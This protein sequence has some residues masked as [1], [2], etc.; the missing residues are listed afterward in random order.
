MTLTDYRNFDLLI[1]R[2][3][4]K[5][6]AIVVDAPA[7]DA[8]AL[9]DLPFAA[10]EITHLGGLTHRV[11]R[12]IGA[13]EDAGPAAALVDLGQR[14]FDA[15]FR[16]RVGAGL[17]ASLSSA[18]QEGV[19]LRLRLRFEEDAADLAALPW[20]LLYDPAQAH[21]IGLGERSPILRYLALPR[22]RSALLVEPPLRVLAVLASPKDLPDLEVE[23]EW[24]AIQDALAG[25][26]TDGKFVLER[27][28]APTLAGLQERLLGEPVHILHFVGHGIFHA[29]S[30][31]G[32]LA[33]EDARGRSHLVRGEQLAA[34]LRNHDRLRLAY[35]NACEGA[36]ASGQ[37]VFTGLAQTLV[38]E[39]VPA[40]VAMQAE[41]SDPGAI[42][43][44]RA[45]Y[46][47]LAAGRPVDASL[48]QARAALSAADSLEWAIPVLFSRSPDNR[49]FDIRAVLPT[50]DCP[51]P[52]MAP[53]SEAQ[54]E[55]FFGRDHEIEDAVQ[56]LRQHPFLAV[57]GSS[58][59]GKS[60][61][62]YAGVIPALRRSKRFGPAPWEIKTM[63]PSDSR[64]ASGQA[65]P[66]QALAQLLPLPPQSPVPSPQ[67]PLPS[68]QPPTL[69]FVDQ[70]EEVFTLADAD[71]A[72]AFLDALHRLIGQP[73]LF[74]LLTVRAD[75]YS[76]LM[77]SP[78]WPAIRA[79]RLELTPLGDDEL[80]A[81]I[82]EPA[83]RVGV[84]V[85]EALA[86]QLIADAAGQRGVLPLVQEALV[87]LWERVE[88]RALK[89]AAYRAMAEGGRSGLQV[90]IDRRA[91]VV[92]ANLPEG[93]Q[94]LARRTF[95]RLIQ[96]GEGR[97]D[98]RRQQTVDELRAHGDD[99]AL[100]NHTL[101]A[102]VDSRLLTTSGAEGGSRRVDIAHEALIAG[103]PRLH[104][105]LEQR[106]AAEQTRRRLEAEAVEWVQ[107]A[108]RGGLLDEYEL[109][110]AESWLAGEDA[111]ELGYSQ[112]LVELTAASKEALVQAKAKD[113][114][115]ARNR[116]RSRLFA[117]GLVLAM[118]VIA[119][120][121]YFA[122]TARSAQQ[123]AENAKATA[124]T[125]A[126]AEA[127]AR[128]QANA[129]AQRAATSEAEAL[130]AKATAEASQAE[131][132]AAK[133]EVERLSRA[134][135]ADQ[136]TANALKVVDESAPLA[137]LLAVEGL[138]AQDDITATQPY[139]STRIS[140]DF[141][142]A[143]Y[144]TTTTVATGN[145]MAVGSAQS[146]MHELLGKVGGAPLA[147][148]EGAVTALAFS[149]DGRWLATGS[150]DD[151]V[152]LWDMAA[153]D[154]AAAPTV[155]SGHED[156]V[157]AL[158]FSPDG[159]WLAT[160]SSDATVRLWD[161]AAADR[162]AAPTVLSGH[163]EAVSALAF[164]PDGRWLATG[165]NDKTVRLWD[166]AAADPAAAPTVLSGHEGGVWALAFSPD[167][168]WL[169]TGSEDAAARLWDMAAADP[170]AAP[171]VLSGHEGGVWALAFSPDGRWLAT[172][173]EDGAVRL[174]DMAAADP[175]AA[176][177]VLSGHEGAVWALAFSP[178]GRWL[179]TGSS[180]ATVRLWDMAAADRAAAPTVLSGHEDGVWAL[181]F[182]PD[183]RWLATGSRDA[184]VRLWDMA[185]ADPAA[186]PTVLSGHEGGVTDLAFSPDGRWLATGSRDA[187]V[188]L[189]G[190]A[191][192]DPAAAPTVLSG[193]EAEVWDL[194][195][196][197]DGRWLATGSEDGAVRLWDM[198]AADPAAAH[199]VLSGHEYGVAALAF[200]PDGRWLA[201]GSRD[202][203]VR[204]W[205]MAAADPA[206]AP[207]VLS[208]HEGGVT[209]LAFSPDG[210]WL[211]T[212]SRDATVRLWGMAA[213]DPAAAPTVLSGHE[214]EVWDLAFSP[215]GRWLATGSEDGAVRLWDMAAA[216]PAAAHTVLS[217]HEYGVAALAFSPDGRWL[218]TGAGDAY[219]GGAVRL[220]DMAAADPAAAPTVLSG[221]EGWVNAL[222]FS[223][224]GRWLA[225]GSND[226]TVRLWD[227]AAADRAAAPTV[228]SGHEAEVTALAFS[229]D[230]RWLA[231][232]SGEGAVRL[233][234]M[235][236]A[237][238]AAAPTVLS[239]HDRW[240]TA[241]AFSPDG[242]W[243]ATGSYDATVPL[244]TWR[245]EDLIALACRTAGR[246]LTAKEWRVYLQDKPYRQTCALWPAHPSAVSAD[247]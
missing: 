66:L 222:A 176:P 50:P 167:G 91:S 186:A 98:T 165:S 210:R 206:A 7:G 37:S 75:F 32:C 219:G 182:S 76:E 148:H 12:H 168:R 193:H 199:T 6:K 88:R 38:R 103:W 217:G 213:A 239:G 177:T 109:Q 40:A 141:T 131:A 110:G 112:E 175:A 223:P 89:L 97:P 81:A 77:A 144:V 21:F 123:T 240:V 87:L 230:G 56:R 231:T 149:P 201:T 105:W 156:W 127:T 79:N 170:A 125:A 101:Q 51:Y 18:A 58:G 124:E 221:H 238:R 214:A 64:T 85:D 82:V 191:A 67:S 24:Q 232:G 55:L 52:G 166:M 192:A 68:P 114:A 151:A 164:S 31:A 190:M 53:F 102:L 169:A 247:G 113:V 134:I 3:G 203:T 92:Y 121:G 196:S 195:F 25:L 29:A 94:P 83:A 60:S 84:S 71:E 2:S 9:F 244:W 241:L 197:P 145:E 93:A 155:L 226:K 47:A 157:N 129:E 235:A 236:A 183:G 200:S 90:A 237:D 33:L 42:A 136:L 233:W 227:M 100:F 80:W 209:D 16:D 65:A 74:I 104:G 216:D 234:D 70:F 63:R 107:A 212:G 220:W 61:L 69:L 205:D 150:E 30:Q 143:I 62:I 146:N 59:S 153:A 36:L 26:T 28:S 172:G 13:A 154:P 116:Q 179:A 73:D 34:L 162:A 152:R 108:R 14:L 215:D 194:A 99:P 115:A 163:E 119:L 184:T 225:T 1:T 198:A 161:M 49:L 19:G 138:R 139:T 147:G 10:D 158:A 23:G 4:D 211:A 57:V 44:A 39:G 8:S 54:R 160:G 126:T 137:L 15:V 189:W 111:Q 133:A 208:G 178:E 245:V 140:Y 171:T 242:R 20:E 106:R 46:S 185:A 202:A 130:A 122:L 228:L 5:Y 95:L 181:A 41:I 174:W 120:V 117:S 43:L 45:F 243:L 246:N 128:L 132:V 207:T 187:T 17:T 72:Q 173:S 118:L 229:P 180:D 224:D 159:R 22:S 48:T 142:Q 204:L 86:V 27:L 11:S 218:A 96:F 78:L 35:L 188:R 135:R